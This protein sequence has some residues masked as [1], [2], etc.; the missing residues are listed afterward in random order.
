MNIKVISPGPLTTVQ[1]LGRY[2]YQRYGVP[3]AGVCDAYSARLANII[4]G[5][6]EDAAVLECTMAGPTLQFEGEG[7]I[8]V[9]GADMAPALN[10]KLFANS[11]AV[12]VRSGDT[13]SFG[14]LRTGLR[15]Y[16]AFF[17]GLSVPE[18]MGSRSTYLKTAMG[19]YKGRKLAAGDTLGTIWQ[20][21]PCPSAD[22]RRADVFFEPK[23]VY[24]IRVVMGPQ[25]DM[26]TR[27]GIDSFFYGTYVVGPAFDRMGMRLEGPEIKSAGGSDIISDGISMGAVQVSSGMP[28]IMLSDRQTTGGYAKIANVISVDLKIL[29]QLKAGDKL[30]FC[31]VDMARAQDLLIRENRSLRGLKLWLDN[32]PGQER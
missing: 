19:G 15:A 14:G 25:D 5:N 9:C 26:F 4:A 6:S 20:P 27:E 3:V 22:G 24:Q 7:L 13:L 12:E 2:G 32:R 1:D 16:I 11:E 29:G 8:A 17:G 28:I 30:R 31:A 18:V 10:G 21:R 23:E